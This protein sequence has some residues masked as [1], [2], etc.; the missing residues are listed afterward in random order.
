MRRR[1]RKKHG[2]EDQCGVS[3]CDAEPRFMDDDTQ[4][5]ASCADGQD[6]TGAGGSSWDLDDAFLHGHSVGGT[7]Q[8]AMDVSED[9]AA[10]AAG[11]ATLHAPSTPASF[12][13]AENTPMKG[14]GGVSSLLA[15]AI[16]P[17]PAG[18]GWTKGRI[19][20]GGWRNLPYAAGFGCWALLSMRGRF[21]RP[22]V[23]EYT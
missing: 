1:R 16:P 5:K 12:A 9:G 22:G 11:S 15:L 19:G 18:S 23:P 14:N 7:D 20:K 2:E 17:P 10:S 4:Q 6:C 8:A 21:R 3:L 13:S